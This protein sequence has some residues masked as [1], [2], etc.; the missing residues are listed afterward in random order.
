MNKILKNS[1][2]YSV[3][4]ILPRAISFIMLPIYTKY[5]SPSD[6]GI[7][8]YTHSVALLLYVLG[9]LSL[10]SYILRYYFIHTDELSRKEML[11]TIHSIIIFCNLVILFAGF[12]FL[13]GIIEQYDIQVPWN[14]YFKLALIINFLDCLTIIPLVVYRVR[15]E[16]IK[17]MLIGSS[18]TILLVLL[19]VYFV[20]IQ[21]KGLLGTYQAQL[22]IYILYGIV[23][24][25]VMMKYS[26][27]TL[28]I[29]YLKEGLRFSLP[30]LPGAICYFFLTVSD[31]VILERNVGIDEL[32]I[33]NVAASLS[34]ALNIVVQSGYKAFEPEMFKKYGT[35][36]Y[37][38]FVKKI[39]SLY[40]YVIYVG[41]L[42]LC[43][44]SQEIFYV[45]TS[46]AFHSGY[47]LVPILVLGVIMT[48]HNV[49]YGGV[50]DGERRT[51]VQG[52]ATTASGILCVSLNIFLVPIGGTIAA[53]LSS[54]VSYILM[55]LFLFYKMTL[56]GKTFFREISQVFILVGI[57]YSIFYL[58][59]DISVL[60][61][62][63]KLL[64][65]IIFS[66]FSSK[67]L[68]VKF[69]LLKRH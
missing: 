19:T 36:D 53:A 2:F 46:T 42:C 38:S 18:R 41:A 1:L 21:H 31:R 55:S 11:G 48:G 25:L 30:L 35:I 58:F 37:F 3:G 40:F 4:E 69:D 57:S 39:Q 44:F 54:A 14:P 56:P 68:N 8:A 5:L 17:F 66:I 23:Y 34:M 13:P 12:L 61:I 29:S 27:L 6:Y 26:K 43:L 50:L 47:L 59:K 20:V 45:M 10:N 67:M 22:Y 33:Y 7:I 9:A 62:I 32:G 65:I 63:V 64:A 15:Q 49:I 51:K 24:S 28:K 60:S 52:F 16:A